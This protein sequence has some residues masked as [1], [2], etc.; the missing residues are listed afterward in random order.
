[1]SDRAKAA[2]DRIRETASILDVLAHYGYHVRDD[3]GHREQQFPCDLHGTGR[4]NKPSARVYPESN[5]WYCVSVAD[6]VLTSG[7]WTSLGEVTPTSPLV[8]NGAGEFHPPLAYL[9]RGTR[10]C[11][12]VRTTAGYQVTLTPD[13]EVEVVG[14]GWV[15]AGR[16][17]PGDVLVVPRPAVPHFSQNDQIPCFVDDLN[18]RSYKGH[19]RLNLPRVWSLGLGEVLGYIFGDGWVTPRPGDSS[20][21]VGLTSSAEDASDARGVFEQLRVWAGGR[22]S[23][24][25]RTGVATTPNGNRY[26]EDQY[27]FSIGND[28]LCEWFQRLGMGKEEASQDRRLPTSLWGATEEA[29]RGFLRGIYA[30]DG[31]VYRPK[32]RK[33]VKVN[34]Y[35]VSRGFLQDI[36]LLLLQFGVYTRLH[37]PAITRPDGVWYLQIATGKDILTFRDLI[38]VANRRKSQ[39]LDSFEYNP[40]GSRAFKPRVAD[41][42]PA[43]DLPV[44]D[45]SMPNEHSFVAGGIKVHNCFA[46]DKT[47]DAI[48]TVRAKE[49]LDFWGAV[50]LLEDRYGLEPLPI[51]YNETHRTGAVEA[52][53]LVL[54]T[55]RTFEQDRERMQAFLDARTRDR[56][57]PLEQLLAFWEV[58]DRVTH[59]VM[60]PAGSGEAW[61]PERGRRMFLELEARINQACKDL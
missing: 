59:M 29:L 35:S 22:G 4:D 52:L 40:R 61:A 36:Q 6:R 15:Q 27:V 23:E 8:L 16:L 18:S 25:H 46:C 30:T 48:E 38:G 41:V 57:L 24:S 7:G 17:Q 5:S 56:D 2:A 11:I 9:D 39:V 42:L 60:L 13:H 28:G 44:A 32:G 31:S 50:R 47:R 3:G 19:P 26:V 10:S 55:G 53:G 49:G 34:L 21:M 54:D 14:Q 1:M 12:T 37:P 20:G 33:G 45:I 58:F 51:D 43:G